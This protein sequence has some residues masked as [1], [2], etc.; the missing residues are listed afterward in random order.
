[1]ILLIKTCEPFNLISY[2]FMITLLDY[3]IIDCYF[4]ITLWVILLHYRLKCFGL[5]FLLLLLWT[6]ATILNVNLLRGPLALSKT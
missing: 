5:I 6:L 4:M 3:F 1:M 2:F